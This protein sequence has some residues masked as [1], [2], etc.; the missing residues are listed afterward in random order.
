MNW[1]FIFNTNHKYMVGDMIEDAI[2][3]LV[4]TGYKFFNWNG[5]IYFLDGKK[6][7]KT[8]ITTKDCYS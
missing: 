6:A 4:T 1:K 7:I 5:D 2:P 3:F 8:G